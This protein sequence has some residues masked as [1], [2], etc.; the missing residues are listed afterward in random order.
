MR[1]NAQKMQTPPGSE[2]RKQ[3]KSMKEK[4]KHLT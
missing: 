3:I 4:E 1:D 2:K